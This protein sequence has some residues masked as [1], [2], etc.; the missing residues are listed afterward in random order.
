MLNIIICIGRA[1]HNYLQNFLINL[2]IAIAMIPILA[3]KIYL[4]IKFLLKN[5]FSFWIL[6]TS[7]EI[8]YHV[9]YLQTS[10]ILLVTNFLTGPLLQTLFENLIILDVRN[11]ELSGSTHHKQKHHQCYCLQHMEWVDTKVS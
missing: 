10:Q 7:P 11:K 4:Q 9:T 8:S 3:S 5:I 2:I 1:I 6:W